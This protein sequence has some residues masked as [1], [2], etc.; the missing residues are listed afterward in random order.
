MKKIVLLLIISC[1]LITGCKKEEKNFSFDEKYYEKSE[2][3]ELEKDTLNE[4]IE[5]KESFGI[6]IYQQ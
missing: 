6:F 5:N 3:I 2:F 1:L 4:L